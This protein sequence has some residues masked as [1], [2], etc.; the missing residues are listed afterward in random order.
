M[1]VRIWYISHTK[2]DNEVSLLSPLIIISQNRYSGYCS[3][4]ILAGDNCS[5]LATVNNYFGA[6]TAKPDNSRVNPKR[7]KTI[8]QKNVNVSTHQQE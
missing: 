8:K 2:A 7:K 6:F 4:I 1:Y 3:F 5:Y